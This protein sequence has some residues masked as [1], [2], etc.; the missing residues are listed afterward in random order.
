MVQYKHSDSVQTGH[1]LGS[2]LTLSSLKSHHFHHNLT[3]LVDEDDARLNFVRQWEDGGC[4]LLRL[5]VPHVGQRGG[6]QVDELAARG[7]GCCLGD[8]RLPTSWRTEQQHTCKDKTVPGN[9]R[10][11]DLRC[12][13]CMLEYTKK[14][15]KV[16]SR[17]MNV[18]WVSCC[19]TFRGLKEFW[20]S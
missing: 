18:V 1:R 17:R 5:A 12:V 8:H 16:D 7:F 15:T 3:D 13:L 19:G 14:N 20:S 9:V 10:E 11:C 6:L 2:Q 4:Q